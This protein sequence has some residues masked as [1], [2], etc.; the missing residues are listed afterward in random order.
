M[1]PSV[2]NRLINIDGYVIHRKDRPTSSRLAK[3][4]GG[5]A[6][7]VKSVYEV[8]VLP[9]P[10]TITS[11]ESNLE[12]IWVKINVKLSRQLIIASI[13]RHPT[14]TQRQI[15]ADLDD[16]EMQLQHILTQYPGATVIIA[17]D[18]NLCIKRNEP[19]LG[20]R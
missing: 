10:S 15:E 3:G 14:N 4:H 2:P 20:A 16:F 12:I 1:T 11:A 7:I 13:Y 8:T 17:G 6:V 19:R 9:T 5:V 18:L